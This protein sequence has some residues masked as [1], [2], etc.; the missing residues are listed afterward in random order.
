MKT[1]LFKNEELI[2]IDLR[3]QYGDHPSGGKEFA[4]VT[5][6]D[7]VELNIK[8]ANIL[9]EYSPYLTVGTYYLE[10]IFE[11]NRNINLEDKHRQRYGIRQSFDDLSEY[12]NSDLNLEAI[13]EMSI[14]RSEYRNVLKFLN[15]ALLCLTKVQRK[16]IYL[17]Y[18]KKLSIRT[19]AKMEGKHH[20]TVD[21]SINSAEKKL[22]EFFENTPTKD[23]FLSI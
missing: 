22:K 8:Y 7:E 11:Y 15:E 10:T 9:A 12:I 21:E 2:I 20:S 4:A 18:W 19:I 3:T 23:L 1:I 17:K 13:I 5:D 16:R 6:L 14:N